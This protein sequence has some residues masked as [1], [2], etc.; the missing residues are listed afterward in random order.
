M[1][2]PSELSAPY[3]AR[4]GSGHLLQS[5]GCACMRGIP[6]QTV[7]LALTS[8]S[9]AWLPRRDVASNP[10]QKQK[11]KQKHDARQVSDCYQ[12]HTSI[13]H[14]ALVC[15]HLLYIH[16]NTNTPPQH[17]PLGASR[18]CSTPVAGFACRAT[19][20]NSGASPPCHLPPPPSHL[21]IYH[22]YHPPPPSAPGTPPLPSPPPA[23]LSRRRVLPA[24]PARSRT[25]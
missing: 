10:K 20:T 4:W 11:Q 22:R 25:R 23:F 3:T 12:I 16:T 13:S 24:R 8:L 21:P 1:D 15:H 7:S 6:I 18:L 2:Q 17:H 14:I 9:L 19:N 5:L